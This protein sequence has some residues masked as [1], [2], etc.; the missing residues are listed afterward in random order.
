MQPA[1]T[2]S[3]AL[4]RR[5]RVHEAVRELMAEQGFR[6]SMDAVAARAG[7][8]KQTLYSH[9]GSKQELMRSVMQEHLDMATAQLDDGQ[10]DIRTVL[11]AFAVEHLQ[12]LSDPHVVTTCQLLSAE[13]AQFPEEAR[14]LYRDGC[15]TLQQ[16][17]AGWLALAMRRGQLRLDDASWAAELLL[18]MIV[19]LDFER[20]RFAF[21]HRDTDALR[22]RWAEYAVDAFLHSF[23]P[24]AASGHA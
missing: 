2:P 1:P 8:S 15:D 13:A 12:R 9:F 23:Q 7:C 18:G 19:G 5:L 17:L 20:Q 11:L 21:P 24:L 3:P 14:T 10:G 22:R 6:I 16:R 4:Q